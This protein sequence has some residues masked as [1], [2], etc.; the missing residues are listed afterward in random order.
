MAG[1]NDSREQMELENGTTRG[2]SVD[3]LK[4]ERPQPKDQNSGT[5]SDTASNSVNDSNT[6]STSA[7]S[8]A[9]PSPQPTK[10]Q[11]AGEVAGSGPLLD[12]QV[13]RI[14]TLHQALPQDGQKGYVVSMWWLSRV[15]SRVSDNKQFG[16]FDKSASEGEVGPI[17]NEPLFD[18]GMYAKLQGTA[19]QNG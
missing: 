11:P 8:D 18:Q 6:V 19:V 14:M 17:N 4:D 10:D 16:P 7:T 3:M 13:S 9:A 5:S 15:L 1:E 12:E 2:T